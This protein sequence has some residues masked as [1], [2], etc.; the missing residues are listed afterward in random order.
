MRSRDQLW[1]I[2]RK[3]PKSA[4]SSSSYG[5]KTIMASSSLKADIKASIHRA[6]DHSWKLI[7]T[8]KGWNQVNAFYWRRSKS[9]DKL[10]WRRRSRLTHKHTSG[11]LYRVTATLPGSV[12]TVSALLRDFNRQASWNRVLQSTHVVEALDKDTLITYLITAI[13]KNW[14]FPRDFVFGVKFGKNHPVAKVGKS[15]GDCSRSSNFLY[16]SGCLEASSLL[17]RTRKASFFSSSSFSIII[18]SICILR[19]CSLNPIDT[20]LS[21]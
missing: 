11:T 10:E 9:L 4:T 7:N 8:S 14:L 13:S 21:P 16:S 17:E 3:K 12:E 6:F 15:I 1:D 2:V 19:P 5:K 20:V 18:S